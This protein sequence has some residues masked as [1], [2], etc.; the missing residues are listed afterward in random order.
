M[1]LKSAYYI[2]AVLFLSLSVGAQTASSPKPAPPQQSS[3]SDKDQAVKRA[4]I[5]RLIEL[6]GAAKVSVDVM[7]Q[8]IAPIRAS[9]P[10]VPEQFWDDFLKQVN[11]D[12]L[13]DL[14]VPVYDKYYSLDDIH[15]LIAFYQ[16]PV[17][18][19]TIKVLPQL[20]AETINA[21]QEW[22]RGLADQIMKKLREKGYDKTSS[23][24]SDGR[25]FQV[26]GF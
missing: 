23:L 19:K 3:A 18:Q 26:S 9:F 12:D 13:I 4:E 25:A 22:G 5:R 1:K 2:I 10:N 16:S 14:V 21:G 20:S 15:D 24:H 7:R 6:T 11:A 8:M 17:G